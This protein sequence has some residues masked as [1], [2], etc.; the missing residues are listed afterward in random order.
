M[1]KFPVFL[2]LLLSGM[3]AIARDGYKIKVR[4]TDK[5]DSMVY[6]AYYFGK[7]LPTIYKTDSARLDKDG[8]AYFEK[9]DKI[10]GGIYMILPEDRKSYFE[11]LLNNGDDISI[12]AT[13]SELP[14]SLKFK[15]SPEN[16]DFMA[17]QKFLKTTAEGQ[18]QLR[19]QLAGAR[20]T[21]DT[22]RIREASQKLNDAVL[23]YRKK[24]VSTHPGTLLGSILRAVEIPQV[25][26]GKHYLPNGKVDSTFGYRYYKDHFWAGFDFRDDRLI[27]TPLLDMK[28]NEFFNKVVYQHEDSVIIYADTI[29]NRMKE[30]E[31]LFKYTLNW[32]STN[33]QTSKVMG[34]D[35]VF[36]HLVVNYYMKGMA[37]WLSNEELNKYVDRAAK[38]APNIL[39]SPAPELK[40]VDQNN[41]PR[42][43]HEIDAKYTLLVFYSPDCGHCMQEMPKLDSLYKAKLRDLGVKVFAFNVDAE[44]EKWRN[45]IKKYDLK[46]WTHVWDPQRKSKYWASYDVIATPAMYL[47]D[48]K[49]II[50][51]KKLDHTNIARVIELTE[52]RKKEGK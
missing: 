45:F 36:V 16:E 13:M 26:E 50:K 28:L 17:Y 14:E 49:K 3:S 20:T 42:T 6:L 46:E 44:E 40:A 32:L 27:H 24:Y 11:F 18:E 39:N 34:M 19:T 48:E 1:K 15:N 37:T 38:I 7:S 25:P 5:R 10:T 2:V 12:T 33:A 4:L 35:K 8:N 22:A 9:K 43:L 47:I 30:S 52:L 51:G 29:L 23:A 41:K 31:N 21:A